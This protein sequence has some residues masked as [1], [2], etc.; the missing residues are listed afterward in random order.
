MTTIQGIKT[1]TSNSK[2]QEIGTL[3]NSFLKT[4]PQG[5]VFAIYTNYQNDFRGDYDLI[6]GCEN[7]K[8]DF[9]FTIPDGD[10][11]E[12]KVDGST[13]ADVVAAWQKI[14][15][16]KKLPRTY[17]VDFEK[18]CSDGSVKIYLSI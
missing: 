15:V 10:Y 6:I 5:E 16:N 2:P 7:G 12:I 18:Y 13:P 4:A 17:K 3:W 8:G 9:E 11:L 1:R 14:W